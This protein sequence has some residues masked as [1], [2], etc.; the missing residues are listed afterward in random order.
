MHLINTY[1]CF[2]LLWRHEAVNFL[3]AYQYIYKSCWSCLLSNVTPW[4][5]SGRSGKKLH[6]AVSSFL[7]CF[8]GFGPKI[9]KTK[10]KER[11]VCPFRRSCDSNYWMGISPT[12]Y[13]HIT[14]RHVCPFNSSKIQKQLCFKWNTS[15]FCKGNDQLW[16]FMLAFSFHL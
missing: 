8:I 4:A 9:K 2:S 3:W 14:N 10:L 5:S 11:N 6:I 7:G 13:K 15:R 16:F 12:I 1:H